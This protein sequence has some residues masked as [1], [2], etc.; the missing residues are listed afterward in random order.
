MKNK[1]AME[2]SINFLVV[3]ILGIAML[4]MGVVFVRKMFT[5]ASEMKDKLD[6]QTEGELEKLMTS[7][8]RVALPYTK[9]EVKGGKTVIFGLGIL[10][11]NDPSGTGQS[12]FNIDVDCNSK[13]GESTCLSNPPTIIN[14]P[15]VTIKN[16]EDE[17]IPIAIKGGDTGTYIIDVKVCRS[18]DSNFDDPCDGSISGIPNAE[19]YYDG[20][21]HKIYVK[22]V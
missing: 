14:I 7:G 21:L 19:E 22:V 17:K 9:K 20:S 10:N 3:M 6:K 16:N 12:V 18:T 15:T 2:L 1:R 13:V 8:E 5:G 4:T 11:V